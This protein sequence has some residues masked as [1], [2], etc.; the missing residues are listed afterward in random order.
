VSRGITSRGINQK[1]IAP[2]NKKPLQFIPNKLQPLQ[3]QHHLLE[4]VA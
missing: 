1:T 3:N 2:L 4:S